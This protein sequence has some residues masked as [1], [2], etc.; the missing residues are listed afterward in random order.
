MAASKIGNYLRARRDLVRPED[1]GMT[2]TRRRRVPGL[3]RDELALLAGISTEYYTRLEQGRDHHPSAQVLDAV[4]RALQLDEDATAHLHNLAAPP[5]RRRRRRRSE[6]VQPS[7]QRLLASWHTT[8]AFVQGRYMDI[9]AA[10]PLAIA[11]SPLYKPGVNVLRVAFLDRAV[12]DLYDDWEARIG[13]VVSGLRALIGPDVDDPYLT[14]LVGELS[15]KSADF[16]R[17]WSRHDVRPQVGGGVHR[18]QHPQV[19][20][21]ELRFDKFDIAGTDGQRLVIYQAEPASTSEQALSLLASIAYDSTDTA[22]GKI[23]AI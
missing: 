16:R 3:R 2:D 23:N 11:L 21:L 20:E 19:G 7:I 4:A 15:V 9:L 17:L 1:V 22:V 14:D 13:G 10:N 8:P 18:F 5:P 12:Q 6:Q